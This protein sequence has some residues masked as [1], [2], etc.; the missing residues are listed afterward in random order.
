MPNY[1]ILKGLF[2]NNDVLDQKTKNDLA[3][4]IDENIYGD[5]EHVIGLIQDCILNFMNNNSE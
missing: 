5:E 3:K 2:M 1:L 4:I